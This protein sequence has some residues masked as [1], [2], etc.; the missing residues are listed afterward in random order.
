MIREASGGLQAKE[1]YDLT[2]IKVSIWMVS[3]KK[4]DQGW[5][6]LESGRSVRIS[7]MQK[8]DDS[9]L[10]KEGDSGKMIWSGHIVNI[11]WKKVS[12]N[13]L[14]NWAKKVKNEYKVLIGRME[15]PFTEM[16]KTEGGTGWKGWHQKFSFGYIKF[17]M[18]IRQLNGELK[19][20]LDI[21]VWSQGRG[22]SWRCQWDNNLR[23]V[24]TKIR[25]KPE[26]KMR[27]AEHGKVVASMA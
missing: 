13:L 7:I 25:F 23:V 21:Q 14:R 17:K 3:G 19:E 18:P 9:G 22:Y 20:K 12:Q 5:A 6:R 24:S 10:D 27:L 15:L 1:W 4:T 26:A 2:Y 16:R 8:R 11:F